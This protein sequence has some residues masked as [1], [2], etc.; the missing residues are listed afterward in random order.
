M[1][2]SIVQ[3]PQLLMPSPLMETTWELTGRYPALC[4]YQ[5]HETLHPVGLNGA[6]QRR[7]KQSNKVLMPWCLARDGYLNT[8]GINYGFWNVNGSWEDMWNCQ[9][10]FPHDFNAYASN[11][12]RTQKYKTIQ[13]FNIF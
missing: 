8:K 1:A 3:A 7:S 5:Q 12:N 11:P 10:A 9:A 6:T 2:F 4:A 13:V